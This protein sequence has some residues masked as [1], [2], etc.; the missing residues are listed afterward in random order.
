[1]RAN[2]DRGFALI[3]TLTLLGLLVLAVCSLSALVKVNGQVGAVSS[4]QYK[5][6]QNALIGFRMGLAELQHHAA[7]DGRVTGMAGVT[8]VLAHSLSTTRNWCGVWNDDGTFLAW[9]TSG[10]QTT[11]A[12]ALASGVTPVN[13]VGS[14]VSGAGGAVG[15]S[16]ANSEHVVAGKIWIVASESPGSPGV[17]ARIGSYA[18]VAL[19]EGVKISAYSQ[20]EHLAIAGLQP[21]LTSLSSKSAQG[22]LRLSI[23]TYS[24]K[25][26]SIISYEQLSVL[27]TP[28]VPLTQSVL[29]DNFH[30]V[31]LTAESLRGEFPVTGTLN[32]NTTSVFVWRSLLE[33][34]NQAVGVTPISR[35]DLATCANALANGFS[36]SASG[37]IAG[38]P[39]LS[40]DGFGGSSLLDAN[41]PDYV[42]A[43][44]LIGAIGALLTVR[45]D[46]FRL[47]AYGEAINAVDGT[48]SEAT[49]Y[50]EAI[51]QRTPEITAT[52]VGR[53]FVIRYFRWLGPDD[54]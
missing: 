15:A 24:A 33:T 46:T 30:H 37:K 43:A 36:G 3:L 8:G 22:K 9:I 23:E 49:A 27:P 11:G 31:T 52:G 2:N 25:L 50:C 45:S 12:P 5:A 41:L 35:S 1:M 29:Q 14:G 32:L 28:L 34:Y 44:D 10:S 21:V 48:T 39:F 6:R 19:D 47:R 13:L 4:S 18:F 20:P 17:S 16:S 7:A 51:L 42:T 53:K 40:V 38:S 26:P 54:L